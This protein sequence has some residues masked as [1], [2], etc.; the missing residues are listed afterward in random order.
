[1]YSTEGSPNIFN[2]P[3]KRS[4]PNVIPSSSTWQL[5]WDGVLTPFKP[6]L[7]K[8]FGDYFMPWYPVE[9]T[10]AVEVVRGPDVLDKYYFGWVERW[11]CNTK[12]GTFGEPLPISRWHCINSR[13]INC[14]VFLL[15]SYQWY[16]CFRSH[17]DNCDRSTTFQPGDKYQYLTSCSLLGIKRK[18]CFSLLQGLHPRA[19]RCLLWLHSDILNESRHLSLLLK[20]KTMDLG[21]QLIYFVLLAEVCAFLPIAESRSVRNVKVS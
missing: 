19:S 21:K 7:I 14:A 10:L 20:L 4:E 17:Q 15:S 9:M 13:G 3:Q 6:A 5:A 8:Y 2:S 16:I 18:Y 1:M 11:H 12:R